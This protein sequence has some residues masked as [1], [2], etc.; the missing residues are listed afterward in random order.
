MRISP[1]GATCFY[2]PNACSNRNAVIRT[3]PH[4]QASSPSSSAPLVPCKLHR[5]RLSPS[6]HP[7][8]NRRASPLAVAN[9]AKGTAPSGGLRWN[10]NAITNPPRE[11]TSFLHQLDSS[12][13][14]R[15]A[16]TLAM[17]VACFEYTPAEFVNGGTVNA[18]KVNEGSCKVLY[19]A[20]SIGL[21]EEQ[22]LRCFGEH[23]AGVVAD[24][25]G[26]GH[27]NIRAFMKQG[28]G[29]L[30]FSSVPLTPKWPSC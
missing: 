17:L 11:L 25:Q 6:S 30:S 5:S 28:F 22:T 21:S 7:H 9:S 23:Y 24:P 15:F 27:A 2:R 12:E 10:G 4:C 1:I 8:Y 3:A 14:V 29:G 19:F 20:L 18:A 13:G 26:S 16:D